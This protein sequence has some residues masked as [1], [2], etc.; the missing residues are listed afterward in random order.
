VE[1]LA[2]RPIVFMKGDVT[3]ESD[4][5]DVFQQ[6]QFWAVLHFAAIKVSFISVYLYKLWLFKY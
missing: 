3:H 1:Q 4:L 2:G 5:E 6:Y